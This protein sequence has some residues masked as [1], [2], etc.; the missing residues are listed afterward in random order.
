M[1]CFIALIRHYQTRQH[2]ASLATDDNK[3]LK[4]PGEGTG[5]ARLVAG[6]FLENSAFRYSE[7]ADFD[8]AHQLAGESFTR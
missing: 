1:A 4:N 8:G 2:N 3:A 6:K 7:T 5:A